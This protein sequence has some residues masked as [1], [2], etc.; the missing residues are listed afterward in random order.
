V[1]PEQ[2]PG[3]REKLD[4]SFARAEGTLVVKT[5]EKAVAAPFC[6]G[7]VPLSVSSTLSSADGGN[8][9]PARQGR[10]ITP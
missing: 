1:L 4:G 6:Q 8:T 3:H 10:G 5:H 9:K 2:G 7:V